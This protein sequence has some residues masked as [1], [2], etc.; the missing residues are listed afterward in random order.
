MGLL[1]QL[2]NLS[3]DQSQGLLGMA[4]A[5]LQ[6]GGPSRMPVGFGQALGAGLQGFQ[7]GVNDSEKRRYL[8]EQ[9]ALQARLLGF[10]VKDAESDLANQQALRDR[11]ARLQ[12]FY[13]GDSAASPTMPSMAPTVENAEKLAAQQQSGGGSS[14]LYSRRLAQAERLRAAGFVPEADAAEASALKF[15]PKVKGWEKVQQDGR[16]LLAPY[17]ED[18]SVGKP[19]PMEVA[20]KLM[21]VNSGGRTDLVNSFTG[22][23]VRSLARTATPDA[24]LSAATARRGQDMTFQTAG[25]DRAQRALAEKAPTEFQGKSAAFGLRAEEADKILNSLQ[26]QYRPAAINSKLAVQQTPLIGGALGAATNFGLT[27]ADQQAEQAQRDFVNAILRQESGAAIGAQEF[28]NARKQYFPQPGDS[29]AVI[30]QK[31]R[32]RQL[33]IQGL[34]TNA[35]KARMT[36]PAAGGW[37]IQRVGE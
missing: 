5:L 4:A 37:S 15:Q 26:G 8:R 27:D 10:K 33:A 11:A 16:V 31:A 23:P 12:Q 22:A 18:G 7:Q 13:M 19:V 35:G 21:E 34:N 28:D 25:L 2:S 17:F 24:L 14:G 9:Q 29:Q 1:D 30:T 32:N 36:A 6:A 20:E 3:P